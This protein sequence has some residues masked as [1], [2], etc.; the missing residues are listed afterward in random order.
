MGEMTADM[1]HR[2]EDQRK[3]LQHAT[4][5]IIDGLV[6]DYETAEHTFRFMKK[7]HHQKKT[8]KKTRSKK[9]K[10]VLSQNHPPTYSREV[11]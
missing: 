4:G 1:W 2:R 3:Q 9:L 7:P 8:R 5:G 6:M 11:A 10:K